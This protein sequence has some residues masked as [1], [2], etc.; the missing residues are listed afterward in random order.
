MTDEIVKKRKCLKNQKIL[1]L[2]LN[3][4]KLIRT[5]KTYATVDK[6]TATKLFSLTPQ[7]QN[8]N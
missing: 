7:Q 3:R 5:F 8:S 2:C 1:P 6:K 4:R